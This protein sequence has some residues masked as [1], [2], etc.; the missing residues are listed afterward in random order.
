ML[1]GQA[2]EYNIHTKNFMNVISLLFSG[3]LWLPFVVIL[4]TYKNTLPIVKSLNIIY[5]L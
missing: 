4:Q 5:V 3:A 2:R 1:R